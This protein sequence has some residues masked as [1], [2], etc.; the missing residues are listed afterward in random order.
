M[1]EF[2]C[3]CMY[4]AQEKLV[5]CPENQRRNNNKKKKKQGTRGELRSDCFLQFLGRH[6]DV[7][8]CSS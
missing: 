5:R 1:Y 3:A 7:E 2:T 8:T 6:L 4:T